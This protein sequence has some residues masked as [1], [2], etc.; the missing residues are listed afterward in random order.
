MWINASKAFD[1]LDN[2]DLVEE[3]IDEIN[4]FD[5]SLIRTKIKK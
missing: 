1:L 2:S 5:D 3:S 4:M